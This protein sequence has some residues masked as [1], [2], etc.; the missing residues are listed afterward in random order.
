MKK[1]IVILSTVLAVIA[2][3]CAHNI[4]AQG[5]YAACPYGAIGYGTFT[6]SKDNVKVK[7]TKDTAAGGVK[8]TNEFTVGKQTTGYDV[9]LAEAVPVK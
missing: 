6:C 9:E 2:S 4:N 7:S 5:L 1:I 8:T 3:G